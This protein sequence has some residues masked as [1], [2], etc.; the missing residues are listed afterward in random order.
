MFVL[1]RRYVKFYKTGSQGEIILFNL[2][3][4]ESMYVQRHKTFYKTFFECQNYITSCQLIEIYINIVSD[5][6]KK[7]IPFLK[8]KIIICYYS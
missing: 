7:Y 4:L 2:S 6:A 5:N 8:I 3:K 1:S